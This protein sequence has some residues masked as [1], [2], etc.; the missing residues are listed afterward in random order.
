MFQITGRKYRMD[1]V[2]FKIDLILGISKSNLDRKLK[3]LFSL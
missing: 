1:C 3:K 2:H